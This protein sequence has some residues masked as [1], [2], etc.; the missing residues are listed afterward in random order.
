MVRKRYGEKKSKEVDGLGRQGFRWPA[1]LTNISIEALD[2]KEVA[3]QCLQSVETQ[4]E[5]QSNGGTVTR[6][7]GRE[8]RV[9]QALGGKG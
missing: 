7:K 9:G 2:I 1:I 8:L 5:K 4:Q 3:G 6:H